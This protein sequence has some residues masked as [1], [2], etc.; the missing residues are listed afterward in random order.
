MAERKTAKYYREILTNGSVWKSIEVLPEIIRKYGHKRWSESKTNDTIN[1][2]HYTEFEWN[3]RIDGFFLGDK[4]VLYADIY[5]Q[6]D[7]TDGNDSVEVSK[8]PYGHV[9][10]GIYEW[11]GDRTY[12]THSDL[13]ITREEFENSLK[14]LAKYL[15]PEEMKKRKEEERRAD[16]N[17]QIFALLAE[18]APKSSRNYGWGHNVDWEPYWN[19]RSAVEQV[20]K[21]NPNLLN[22]TFEE[23]KPIVLKVYN[24]NHKSDYAMRGGWREGEKKFNLEY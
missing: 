16:L 2:R 13:R 14:A 6:G 5:W 23:L 19:G 8:L 4:G 9:I 20:L 17:K 12:E 1:L 24:N 15:S 22:K 11:L 3:H 21:N 10:R 18:D 7:S